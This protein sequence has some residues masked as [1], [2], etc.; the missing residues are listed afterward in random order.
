MSEPAYFFIRCISVILDIVLPLIILLLIPTPGRVHAR[1]ND[2]LI[3]GF[4]RFF[5][6][7][8]ITGFLFIIKV[9]IL[10]LLR[11]GAFG[12]VHIVYDTVFISILAVAVVLFIIA[13]LRKDIQLTRFVKVVCA[14]IIII[15]PVI[16]V[17]ATWIEPY[18]VQFEKHNVTVNSLRAGRHPV[19]I[20]V[21]SDIQTALVSDHEIDAVQRVLSSEPDV[22]LI[23]GDLFSGRSQDLVTQREPLRNLLS[24]LTA[25]GGVFF[26]SG[27]MEESYD[28]YEL[29][30]DLP[31]KIINNKIVSINIYDRKITLAGITLEHNSPAA[32]ETVKTL[33]ILPGTDDIRILMTHRPD[34]VYNLPDKGNC[35]TDLVIS[36]HTHGGQV[37]I[38]F[39]G[40]PLKLTEVPR[41][42][43]A[44]GKVYNMDG[45]QI[46][47][48]RGLGW[49]GN[50]APRIRFLCPPEITLLTI[51]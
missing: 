20:G 10:F 38:P 3:I 33:E 49:E 37:A 26:V 6:A 35:R 46:Y 40:P 15:F 14:G 22:I 32:L 17:D 48:S 28:V 7:V 27:N 50:R 13:C 23:P 41:L 19:K 29:L 8:L 18:R 1:E 21:L 4:S 31:I 45:R 39:F 30:A 47:V 24:Q 34:G 25:P 51:E 9:V 2:K 12:V 16:M 44:G 11:T 42:V 43:A 36:G 5:T